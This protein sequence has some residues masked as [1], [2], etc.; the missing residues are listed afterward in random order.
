MTAKNTPLQ[1][2]RQWAPAAADYGVASTEPLLQVGDFYY[3]T[4]SRAFRKCDTAGFPA[5]WSDLSGGNP[6]TAPFFDDFDDGG[7]NWSVSTSNNGTAQLSPS[8]TPLGYPSRG[9]ALL[10]ADTTTGSK[11][12]IVRKNTGFVLGAASP[13]IATYS[14]AGPFDGAVA[15]SDGE[16]QWFLAMGDETGQNTVAIFAMWVAGVRSYVLATFVGGVLSTEPITM[17]TIAKY[18]A[19]RLTITETGTTVEV[20]PDGG[21]FATV[22]TGVNAPAQAVYSPTIQVSKDSGAGDRTLALDY[23]MVE[24]DR[25]AMDSGATVP[26]AS[27]FGGSQDILAF[28]AGNSTDVNFNN[29][30]LLNVANPATAQGVA[31]KT[32]SEA[33]ALAAAQSF[34]NINAALGA[35]SADVSVNNQKIINLSDPTLPGDAATKNYVDSGDSSTL[36]SA[37]GTAATLATAAAQNEAN[38]RTAAAALTAP[39]AILVNGL[40]TAPA[41]TFTADPNTGIWWDSSGV[42]GIAGDGLEVVRFQAP[43]GANPQALFASG[44]VTKPSI[45]MA[46]SPTMGFYY[47]GAGT[48]LSLA[49]DTGHAMSFRRITGSQFGILY[50][51][52]AAGGLGIGSSAN[53]SYAFLISRISNQSTPAALIAQH[54]S[55]PFTGGAGLSQIGLQI[56]HI[57]TQTS[58]AAFTNIDINRTETTLGSGAQ[59]II[60]AKAG[61]AGT[62]Q[63]FAVTNAGKVIAAGGMDAG[64]S[65]ITNTAQGTATGE[66][67]VYD[68]ATNASPV[69][70]KDNGGFIDKDTWDKTLGQSKIWIS[71]FH[72][73][74]GLGIGPWTVVAVNGGSV[75]PSTAGGMPAVRVYCGATNAAGYANIHPYFNNVTASIYSRYFQECLSVLDVRP[76]VA[77]S[78]GDDFGAVVCF[79]GTTTTGVPVGDSLGFRAISSSGN[80]QATKWIGGVVTDI[81]TGIATDLLLHR[82]RIEHIVGT[83]VTWYIDGVQVAQITSSFPTISAAYLYPSL[84]YGISFNSLTTRS[85][86]TAFADA[87]GKLATARN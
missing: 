30:S 33:A 10:R 14:W 17:P 64:A 28:F 21:A 34:P 66:V 65:K 16:C 2:N 70:T 60:N 48:V 87:A 36:A 74:F 69:A 67:L 49:L 13:I 80:W 72:D 85:V 55:V 7:F 38:L 59:Y 1:Q 51:G 24:G 3:N 57:L 82:F 40:V 4:V 12:T 83:S 26:T 46:A 62:T 81:D 39:F 63:V 19:A 84:V 53:G 86:R 27:D 22:L 71:F 5:L 18:A 54:S 47:G 75:T 79:I 56:N 68:N 77:V 6:I 58:T 43:T 11:S 31:T 61:V 50:E 23:V 73:S 37:N 25:A 9:I 44:S 78:T 35:A 41:I 20:A 15:Y 32:S 76:S 45:A 8:G 42:L 29:V 52:A